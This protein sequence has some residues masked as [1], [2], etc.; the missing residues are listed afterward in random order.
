[1][2]LWN[3]RSWN[4]LLIKKVTMETIVTK[5]IIVTKVL[6]CYYKCICDSII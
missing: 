4:S 6:L 3:G 1:M 2:F 5:V